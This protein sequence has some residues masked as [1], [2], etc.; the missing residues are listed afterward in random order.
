[1][2]GSSN[3]LIVNPRTSLPAAFSTLTRMRT[4]ASSVGVQPDSSPVD[5]SITM[6]V[7]PLSSVWV[8]AGP[9]V[10]IVV[11]YGVPTTA[12]GSGDVVA[13]AGGD[14]TTRFAVVVEVR[15]LSAVN[16]TV[17]FSTGP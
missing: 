10:A 5:A 9:V 7:G 16:M 12:F 4:F 1:M 14:F 3:G 13:K 11:E 6:P 8:T 15:P 2:A 17:R